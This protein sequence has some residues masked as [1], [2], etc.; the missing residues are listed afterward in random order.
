MSSGEI[1]PRFRLINTLNDLNALTRADVESATLDV[2]IGD[3]REHDFDARA[4]E[5]MPE[6]APVLQRAR[7]A[8]QRIDQAMP[9]DIRNDFFK[10][11]P[12]ILTYAWSLGTRG[13]VDDHDFGLYLHKHLAMRLVAAFREG[14]G[15]PK[16]DNDENRL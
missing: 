3:V 12:A 11:P 9:V 2:L 8:S 5:L 15:Y 13:G 7:A 6:V 14:Y 16:L 4:M 10:M 1:K